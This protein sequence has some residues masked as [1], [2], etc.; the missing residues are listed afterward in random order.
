M[1]IMVEDIIKPRGCQ[2]LSVAGYGLRG[3]GNGVR[4]RRFGI[5]DIGYLISK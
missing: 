4:V 5:W 2:L 3:A 1:E